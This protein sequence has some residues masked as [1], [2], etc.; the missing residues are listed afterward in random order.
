MLEERSNRLIEES[1]YRPY[2]HADE[3]S[4]SSVVYS[5]LE[6]LIKKESVMDAMRVRFCSSMSLAALKSW[7]SFASMFAEQM[8]ELF[9]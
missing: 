2:L 6:V 1:P 8:S 5:S 7:P 4:P 9:K 3:T